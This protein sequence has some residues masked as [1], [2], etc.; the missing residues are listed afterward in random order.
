M[1][2]LTSPVETPLHRLPAG[3]KLGL[4]CAFTI[5]LFRLSSPLPL[6]AIAGALAMAHLAL[7]TAIA[8]QQQNAAAGVENVDSEEGEAA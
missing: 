1:L 4:L 5:L 8:A 2:T 7:G 6:A 3:L